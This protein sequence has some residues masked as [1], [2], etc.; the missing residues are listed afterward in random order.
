MKRCIHGSVPI[1]TD[2]E[3]R[4]ANS[5]GGVNILVLHNASRGDFE[6]LPEVLLE[7]QALFF[8]AYR[9]FNIK[10]LQVQAS[11]P[12]EMAVGVNSGA[13]C[14]RDRDGVHLRTLEQ[15]AEVAILQPHMLEATK[16]MAAQQPGSWVSLLLAYRRPVIGFTRHEQRLISAALQGGTDGE[17]SHQLDVSLSA[18][19][20]TWASIYL[21]VQ[22]RK[23]SDVKIE[24][25]GT[26]GDRGWR[27][28]ANIRKS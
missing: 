17:L 6:N 24:L 12:A 26:D 5:T 22:S 4:H 1:L 9:G 27:I 28:C 7:S 23:P 15:P 18:V 16:E 21:R 10:R 14:L 2:A 8:D 11:H 19:K 13:W 25:D 3:V 20:K